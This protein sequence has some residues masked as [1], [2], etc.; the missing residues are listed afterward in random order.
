MEEAPWLVREGAVHVLVKNEGLDLRLTREKQERLRAG[1]TTSPAGRPAAL[2]GSGSEGLQETQT[3]D[4]VWSLLEAA[5]ETQSRCIR[6][7]CGTARGE[8]RGGDAGTQP[9]A[10]PEW[11]PPG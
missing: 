7:S 5:E 4:G 10:P 2:R 9:R 1:N 3:E 11:E 6:S 8:G